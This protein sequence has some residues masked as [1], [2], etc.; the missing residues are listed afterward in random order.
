MSSIRS[1]SLTSLEGALFPTLAGL[2]LVWAWSGSLGDAGG[3]E[4]GVTKKSE[5]LR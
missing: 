2:G 4:E 3:E 5:L 1:L